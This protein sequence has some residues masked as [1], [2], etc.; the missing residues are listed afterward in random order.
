MSR[1]SL[2]V[3]LSVATAL[4]TIGASEVLLAQNFGDLP[5]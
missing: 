4:I 1:I 2:S 5:P 3:F